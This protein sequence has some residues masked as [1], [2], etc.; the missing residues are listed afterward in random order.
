MSNR[1]LS[2]N[3][4][5]RCSSERCC[6]ICE[7]HDWCSISADGT[8]CECMRIAEGSIKTIHHKDGAMGYLHRLKSS[9][10]PRVPA[11]T[12]TIA[13]PP[14]IHH[15]YKT[16]VSLLRL[17]A[18]HRDALRARGLSDARIDRCG[19]R[20]F[21]LRG[22]S[23][24]AQ[25][26]YQEVGERI[27]GVPGF[28]VKTG[29]TGDY[30]TM[31]G[32][33]GLMIPILD[34]NRHVVA[35][36]I[37]RD[38]VTVGSNRYVFLS[39]SRHGGPKSSGDSIHIPPGTNL[40]C[41]EVRFTEGVFKAELTTEKTLVSTIA[42]ASAATWAPGIAFL[43]KHSNIKT[44]RLAY[45][46][47]Y[48]TNA[49]VARNLYSF[50][51][52]LRN[53]GKSILLEIWDGSKAKGIDDALVAGL[54]IETL[55]NEKAITEIRSAL[56]ALGVKETI[57]KP[58]ASGNSTGNDDWFNLTDLGNSERFAVKNRESVKFAAGQWFHWDG[59]CWK[60]DESGD[61]TRRAKETVRLIYRAAV[62]KNEEKEEKIRCEKLREHAHKSES[63]SR[64][65]AM[66]GLARSEPGI[67]I[68]LDAF[69]TNPW[70]LNC[71]NGTIDLQT[72]K[73]RP[74]SKRDLL[75]QLCPVPYDPGAR[76]PLWEHFL[77]SIFPVTPDAAEVAGDQ[78]KIACFRRLAG[79]T[80]T[81]SVQEA[82][83]TVLYGN[84][85]NGKSVVCN[86][87]REMLGK[88]YAIRAPEG[89]LNEHI[90]DRHPAELANLRGKRFV[91]TSETNERARFNEAR[92]KN[93]TGGESIRARDYYEKFSEFKPT[94]KLWFQ[95]N[96]LPKVSGT[97]GGIWRR[98]VLWHLP[99]NFWDPSRP[100]TPG[101][102]RLER[103][104]QDKNLEKKLIVELPG[105]L[106]WA[107]RGCLEWQRD[108][109]AIPESLRAKTAEYREEEDTIGAFITDLCLLSSTVR[110]RAST[111][112]S[113]YV[114]WME[115]SKENPKPFK[116]FWR[117]LEQR[118]I[119]K[120]PSNGI[121]YDGI[122]LRENNTPADD[123][124]FR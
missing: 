64:I 63:A 6:P 38:D 99:V 112:Y 48:R 66:I 102:V 62:P 21:P 106:A 87:F 71:P 52:E 54:A 5:I 89:F 101:E 9:E 46:A 45:D 95:S 83:V 86:L 117:Y 8:V 105:I 22:R 91:D 4:W 115:G 78:E 7:R 70:V 100:A 60:A 85:G 13:D 58:L 23:S 57:D 25:Q 39:S 11:K 74:H 42:L 75:T 35:I 49:V 16:L 122:T 84:G 55:S 59:T 81:G 69:N 36:K 82:I 34:E 120:K 109:L 104:K 68:S 67:P 124:M 90:G 98:L 111:L 108:G 43:E 65:A 93:L 20:T 18:K 116:L 94:H 17:N 50:A 76:C 88:D 107:V 79:Y 61:I 1:N 31:A 92:V 19:Y 26:V 118:G 3:D 51:M 30:L 121:W 80:L 40:D 119:S 53:Q 123:N 56:N 29:D 41:E 33:P 32:P 2:Q 15:A 44:V 103:L 12:Q 113:A 10:R 97:D 24:I 27:T 77:E 114:K 14:T 96:H 28:Y 110:I 37:R 47:D 72:G 73:L